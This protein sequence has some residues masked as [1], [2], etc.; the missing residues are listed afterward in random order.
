MDHSWW[1]TLTP[2]EHVYWIIAIASSVVLAIQLVLAS[3]SGLDFHM[4]SDLAAHHGGDVDVPHFQLMTIRNIVAFFA[5]FSWVGLA[6]HHAGC[7]NVITIGVSFV[8]GLAMMVLL[9][10][11]FLGLSKL[12]TSGTLDVKKAKGQPAET[13]LTI[14]PARK[15]TGKIEVVIQGKKVEMDAVTDDPVSIATG[16]S[17]KIIDV[18]NNQ[19]IVERI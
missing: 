15:S 5:V 4:G 2:L 19:A 13:Y 16:T 8:S 6:L 17:V 18:V 3:V 11:M 10:L 1:G 14:P 12:Q 9:A 7:S